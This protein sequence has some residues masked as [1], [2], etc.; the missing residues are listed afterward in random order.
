ML[1]QINNCVSVWWITVMLLMKLMLK[2]HGKLNF[3]QPVTAVNFLLWCEYYYFA[4]T[5]QQLL[6]MHSGVTSCHNQIF[7]L[8]T[9]NHLHVSSLRVKLFSIFIGCVH[10]GHPVFNNQ[11]WQEM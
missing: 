9:A 2:G 5:N 11:L 7:T 8:L 4:Q 6:H 1:Q 10:F 3:C